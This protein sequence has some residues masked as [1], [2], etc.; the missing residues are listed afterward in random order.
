M[1]AECGIRPPQERVSE[2]IREQTVDVLLPQMVEQLLEVPKI[3]LQD[4]ILQQTVKQIADRSE[5]KRADL[6]EAEKSLAASMESQAVSKSSHT[7]VA[8]D[9]E[10][11]GRAFADE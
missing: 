10:A 1:V 9:H 2:R 11:S 4:R 3:I 5:A 8:S 6:A 7:Q